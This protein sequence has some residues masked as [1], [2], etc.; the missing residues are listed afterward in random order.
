MKFG[1][2]EQYK[3]LKAK[4]EMIY[5]VFGSDRGFKAIEDYNDNIISI[6]ELDVRLSRIER[7]ESDDTPRRNHRFDQYISV[8]ADDISRLRKPDVFR[9]MD[10]ACS[11]S[12]IAKYIKRHRPD[13]ESEVD[14]V[15]LELMTETAS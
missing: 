13:L 7:E 9:V 4:A 6:T 14:E 11:K 2:T 10:L 5:N 12:G 15:L 1:D 8:A 3:I